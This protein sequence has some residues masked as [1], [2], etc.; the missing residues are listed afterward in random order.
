MDECSSDR[1]RLSSLGELHSI[2]QLSQ[3][4]NSYPS[5]DRTL[6]EVVGFSLLSLFGFDWIG[7]DDDDD[8]DS[9]I[10]LH[11]SLLGID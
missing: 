2:A 1:V 7:R 4:V 8:Y 9:R 10:S 6:F 3:R 11:W 5:C